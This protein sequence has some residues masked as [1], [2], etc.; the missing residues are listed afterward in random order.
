MDAIKIRIRTAS[1][2]DTEQL[3]NIYEPYVRNSAITFEY[4]VPTPEEFEERIRH[5]LK[6]YPYLVAEC[7]GEILGYA[8]TG[9]FKG[10]AAYDWA[11]ETTIYLREGKKKIGIGKKLYQALEEVSRIQNILNLNACIGYPEAEDEYLDKNSAQFHEHMGYRLVGEFYKCG[12]KF[13]RWYNMVWMEKI[14]GEHV[15]NPKPMIPFSELNPDTVN[16]L[17]ERISDVR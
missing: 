4:D 15:P 17:L 1:A 2:A 6:K 10:R 3:L 13:G 16:H 14:I 5:T 9:P 11:V 7:D 12:C 8:Y